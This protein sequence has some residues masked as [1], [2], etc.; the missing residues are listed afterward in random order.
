MSLVSRSAEPTTQYV[1][2]ATIVSS[3]LLM[4]VQTIYSVP[5]TPQ[6]NR[7]TRV[8]CIRQ[9]NRVVD[10]VDRRAELTNSNITMSDD[11]KVSDE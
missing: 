11:R 4:A 3:P 8:I 1:T 9:D 5:G 10:I 2:D 6:E 7:G